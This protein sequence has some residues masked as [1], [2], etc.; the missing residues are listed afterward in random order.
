MFLNKFRDFAPL[1]DAEGEMAGGADSGAEEA[2]VA[3]QSDEGVEGGAEETEVADQSTGE[4]GGRTAADAAFA[5]QRRRI[6]ELEREKADYEEALG[7]FFEGEGDDVLVQARA[8]GEQKSEEQVRAEIEAENERARL[9]QENEEL[10]SDLA[11]REAERLMA[12][13]LKEIQAIDPNVKSLDD[14]GSDFFDLISTGQVTGVQ[15]YYAVKAR[16]ESEKITPPDAIGKVNA[17]SEPKDFF[18]R[19]EVESMSQDEVHKNFDTIRRS[20]S[21]W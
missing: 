5:E 19:E 9:E 21:K 2:G 18:S 15:A 11:S 13:D 1:L 4:E 7:L 16:Q 10:R 14:L 12:E 8:L 17:S 6:E 3:A 20:M